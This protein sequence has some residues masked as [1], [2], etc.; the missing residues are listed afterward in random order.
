[1]QNTVQQQGLPNFVGT[2]WENKTG[3]EIFLEFQK[4]VP[5]TIQ[6]QFPNRKRFLQAHMLDE[7]DIE[8]LGNMGLWQAIQ[9]YDPSSNAKFESFVISSISWKIRRMIRKYSLR[10]VRK[11]GLDLVDM[12]S[13]QNS[14]SNEEENITIEDSLIDENAD[15]ENEAVSNVLI[16]K[17]KEILREEKNQSFAKKMEFI[18]LARLGG[19]SEQQIADQL[20]VS[21]QALHV[22]MNTQRANRFREKLKII[23]REN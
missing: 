9:T 22:F 4:Y 12:I 18:I 19:K 5:A 8:Q 2:Q 14:V 15:I 6:K 13:T 7:D 3:E 10:N 1:M 17:A 21:R 23:C 11:N 16:E 20:G